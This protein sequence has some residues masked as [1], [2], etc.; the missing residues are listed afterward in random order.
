MAA[1]VRIPVEDYEILL[2]AMNDQRVFIIGRIFS[3]RTEK[4]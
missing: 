2:P 4:A 3:C 1:D